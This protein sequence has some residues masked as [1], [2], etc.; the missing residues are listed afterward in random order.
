MDKIEARR[1]LLCKLNEVKIPKDWKIVLDLEEGQREIRV[2]FYK[3]GG[4][5]FKFKNKA[6]YILP[7]WHF[8]RQISGYEYEDILYRINKYPEL[9]ET[10]VTFNSNV[11]D[12]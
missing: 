9:L 8:V 2:V 6:Y 10:E 7:Y 4:F 5:K 1:E 12:D 11:P 3:K